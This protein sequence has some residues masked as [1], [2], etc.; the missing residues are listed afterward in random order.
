MK[1]F[2][3]SCGSV[4]LYESQRPK[5]CCECGYS[6]AGTTPP[7]RQSYAPQPAPQSQAAYVDIDDIELD[8]DVA[9]PN[10]GLLFENVLGSA[11]LGIDR[12]RKK[13]GKAEFKKIEAEMKTFRRIDVSE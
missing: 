2:C 10:K 12:P 6:M 5:F 11:P 9:A 4:N 3:S 8:I 1:T 7:Q 13:I